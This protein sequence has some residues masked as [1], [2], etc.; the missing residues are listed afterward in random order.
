MHT[1]MNIASE[2]YM[3]L[4]LG[5]WC[6]GYGRENRKIPIDEIKRYEAVNLH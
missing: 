4:A 6:M 3:T 2:I 5:T 1:A